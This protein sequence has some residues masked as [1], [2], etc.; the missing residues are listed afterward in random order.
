MFFVSVFF[1]KSIQLDSR[2]SILLKSNVLLSELPEESFTD[3]QEP[4]KW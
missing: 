3:A 4:F 1:Q 2:V